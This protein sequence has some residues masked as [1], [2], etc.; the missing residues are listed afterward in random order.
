VLDVAAISSDTLIAAREISGVGSDSLALWRSVDGGANWLPFQNGLGAGGSAADRRVVALLS[1]SSALLAATIFGRI[2][3]STDGG[4]TWAKVLWSGGT[5][6]FYFLTGGNAT[7]W[8]G[9]ETTIGSPILFRSID[10]GDTWVPRTI[11]GAG[12]PAARG[13]A[14]DPESDN[15]AFVG[16]YGGLY[17]TEN[18]GDSW[19]SIGIPP[20]GAACTVLGS[21]S[22]S[23]A[24][25]YVN[26]SQSQG[27]T[28]FT[29]DDEGALWVPLT[30]SASH[31]PI[32]AMLIRSSGAIDSVFLGT[33]S[34]ILQYTDNSLV[35]V[36]PPRIESTHLQVSPN[37]SKSVFV[38]NCRLTNATYGTLRVFDAT[39]R[40]VAALLNGHLLAGTH[41]VEWMTSGI[42][43]GLF[44]IELKTGNSTVSHKVV[45]RR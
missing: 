4:A 18:N 31:G 14:F 2:A 1:T 37:P 10:S 12:A 16:V 35:H 21:R 19:T 40:E 42:A 36:E 34:G 32:T 6:F 41:R 7:V 44:L 24:R 22:Y 30:F 5:Y 29:T 11:P 23:P 39:G 3:K 25:L 33:V 15:H 45:I 38:I 13:M 20:A 17:E 9:G 26:G 28:V 43:S 8:A 27:A